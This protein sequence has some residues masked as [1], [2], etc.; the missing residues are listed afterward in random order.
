MRIAGHRAT[1]TRRAAQRLPAA[2]R[3][4]GAARAARARGLARLPVASPA[5][6]RARAAGGGAERRA[7]VRHAEPAR[8]GRSGDLR[9]RRTGGQT[10]S[11][12]LRAHAGRT[13]PG[14]GVAR[15]HELAQAGAR[16]I[17]PQAGGGRRG[18]PGG[19]GRDRRPA[20]ACAVARRSARPS[21]PRWPSRTGR[22]PRC[23]SRAWCSGCRRICAG[24][25]PAPA[26]GTRRRSGDASQTSRSCRRAA[27]ARTTAAARGWSAPFAT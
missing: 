6:A 25:R 5:G 24:S 22:S 9:A 18:R 23:S 11:Q 14:H 10:R 12:G 7:G 27:C 1:A 21:A 26:T 16:R 13:R 2:G 8:E 15:G 3:P 17:P 19:P 4:R 20:A